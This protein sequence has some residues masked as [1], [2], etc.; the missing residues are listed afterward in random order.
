MS[1]LVNDTMLEGIFLE[2]KTIV[3]AFLA[4]NS[5]PT[6]HFRPELEGINVGLPVYRMDI[7]ENP[8]MARELKVLD[9]PTTV[10]YRDS[11]ELAR[12]QGP[13]SRESL[14]ERIRARLA[15]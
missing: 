14:E 10:L 15:I 9:S 3:V 13:Y 11:N 8:T 5:I 6:E 1:R 7:E 4:P 12:W 2:G